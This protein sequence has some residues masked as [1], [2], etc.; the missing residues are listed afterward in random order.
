MSDDTFQLSS[1][2]TVYSLALDYEQSQHKQEI[3]DAR[4]AEMTAE[5]LQAAAEHRRLKRVRLGF[6]APADYDSDIPWPPI[7]QGTSSK[8]RRA[9]QSPRTSTRA[10]RASAVKSDL[11]GNRAY[12]P[13]GLLDSQATSQD[14]VDAII[15]AR[16]QGEHQHHVVED[17]TSQDFLEQ[18]DYRRQP[19]VYDHND[20]EEPES[21]ES[22]R[23]R[24]FQAEAERDRA[25]E[26]C[27]E[28]T[29]AKDQA[30]EVLA[31]WKRAAVAAMP[32]VNLVASS[33]H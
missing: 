32:L 13:L 8:P 30:E 24:C 7:N 23:A 19:V 33:H 27:A 14:A 11:T 18:L 21:Y 22:L 16:L 26:E 31:H 6:E 12:M 5:E 4:E 3:R 1:P 20:S 15:S 17:I 10:P 25:L 9:V 2:S 28:A 29:A